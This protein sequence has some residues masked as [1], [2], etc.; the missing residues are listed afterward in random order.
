MRLILLT[1]NKR[2]NFSIIYDIDTWSRDLNSKF[3]LRNCL[4]GGVKLATN[5]DPDKYIYSGYG[6]RFNSRSEFSFP[7]GS[8]GKN[9]LTFG[10]DMNSSSILIIKEKI[11]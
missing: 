8:M 7:D 1:D 6:M 2:I 3:N 10:V 11:S 9:V 5:A 4:F